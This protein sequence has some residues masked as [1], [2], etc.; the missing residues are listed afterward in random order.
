MNIERLNRWHYEGVIDQ[1]IQFGQ[2]TGLGE[3]LAD[4]YDRDYFKKIILH[5]QLSGV[6][7]VAIE[8]NRVIGMLLSLRD[9][10]LWMPKVIRLRE[11]CWW[12]EPAYRNTRAGASLFLEY[13]RLADQM[14][15]SGSIVS[16][17]I[18][19]LDSSSD[20]DFERRGFKFLE[21]T[22]IKGAV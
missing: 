6:S 11:V 14:V 22:W 5:C 17:S 10:D 3:Y 15:S 13:V 19:R 9:R 7:L 18:S 2:H 1:I 8:Q 16:Y 21:S 4:S 12:V 20:F